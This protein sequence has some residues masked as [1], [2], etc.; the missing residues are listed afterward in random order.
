[1]GNTLAS[2]ISLL[3]LSGITDGYVLTADSSQAAKC[4]WAPAGGGGYPTFCGV[5]AYTANDT[6]LPYTGGGR[7]TLVFDTTHIAAAGVSLNTGTGEITINTTGKYR[8]SFC[9]SLA[10]T[11]VGWTSARLK[12]NSTI[13][14]SEKVKG[15]TGYI[16]ETM[17]S[18]SIVLDLVATDKISVEMYSQSCDWTARGYSSPGEPTAMQTFI[19]VERVA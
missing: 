16:A 11:S 18:L 13:M 3:G 6:F 8:I 1:M 15:Y 9:V 19:S 12:K 4:K 17:I 7:T 10:T 2:Y 14:V 5:V